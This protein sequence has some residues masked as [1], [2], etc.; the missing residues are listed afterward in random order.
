ML[1]LTKAILSIVVVTTLLFTLASCMQ[2]STSNGLHVLGTYVPGCDDRDVRGVPIKIIEEDNYGRLL[3]TYDPAYHPFFNSD[4]GIVMIAQRV[5]TEEKLIYYYEDCF[6]LI[7]RDVIKEWNSVEIDIN[8]EQINALK[9]INDWNKELKQ[10]KMSARTIYMPSG[11]IIVKEYVEEAY[12]RRQN[13]ENGIEVKFE[14]KE[15]HMNFLD[16][17][18]AGLALH[19]LYVKNSDGS[20]ERYFV[21]TDDDCNYTLKA[22]PDVYDCCEVLTSF[23]QENGW[24]FGYVSEWDP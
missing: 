16:Y 21:L 11:V 14:G 19:W 3:C 23:K 24:Q 10:E 13:I 2:V 4:T 20:I 17:D 18:G 5:D 22:I 12:E 15:W 8:S 9:A 7:C 1:R 6:F